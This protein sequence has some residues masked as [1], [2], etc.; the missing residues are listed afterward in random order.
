MMLMQTIEAELL[1]FYVIFVD[2]GNSVIQISWNIR[3]E[4]YFY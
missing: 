4:V 2:K 3:G 1:Y